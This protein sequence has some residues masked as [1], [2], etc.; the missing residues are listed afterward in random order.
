M[1][2]WEKSNETSLPKREDFYSH[3]NMEKVI[4]ADYI[5][6]KRICKDFKIKI[7]GKSS[8]LYIQSDTLAEIREC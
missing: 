7:L 2:D 6:A 8:D 1:D 4:D 3:L 5:H